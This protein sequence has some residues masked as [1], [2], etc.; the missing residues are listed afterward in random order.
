MAKFTTKITFT[1]TELNKKDI[2]GGKSTTEK[3]YFSRLKNALK[4]E[5]DYISEYKEKLNDIQTL[6]YRPFDNKWPYEFHSG[7]THRMEYKDA[8]AY[9][10]KYYKSRIIDFTSEINEIQ[11]KLNESMPDDLWLLW[12]AFD[13]R[14]V[15]AF[16]STAKDLFSLLSDG[17]NH[18]I[19]G[20][21]EDMGSY[22]LIKSFKVI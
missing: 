4:M 9:L 18:D 17:K 15:K 19:N 10:I 2:K 8:K 7:D 3:T 22:L 12:F 13:G 11:K 21:I 16:G 14:A 1:I 5:S 6:S 20:T